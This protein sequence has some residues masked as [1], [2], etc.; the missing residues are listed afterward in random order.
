MLP[1]EERSILIKD[2]GIACQFPLAALE[3]LGVLE[4]TGLSQR[5]VVHIALQPLLGLG[6]RDL[7]DADGLSTA[8]VAVG[9]CHAFAAALFRLV[10]VG[11]GT[12]S[13]SWLDF[14]SLARIRENRASRKIT[15]GTP[16]CW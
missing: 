4:D 8:L 2:N 11:S 15:F 7:H 16:F 10:F 3:H 14:S 9:C 12:S 1:I 13:P 5:P 6:R